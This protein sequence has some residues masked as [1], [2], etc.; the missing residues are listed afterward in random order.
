VRRLRYQNEDLKPGNGDCIHRLRVLEQP[1]SPPKGT[2]KTPQIQCIYIAS[3]FTPDSAVVAKL[4]TFIL[5]GRFSF[6]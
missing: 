1:W 3:I 4:S 2:K 6:A 5:P